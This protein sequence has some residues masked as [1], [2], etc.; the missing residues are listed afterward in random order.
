MNWANPT[1]SPGK[2]VLIALDQPTGSDFL[3]CRRRTMSF[4]AQNFALGIA[5]IDLSAKLD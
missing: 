3:V 5:A 1:A 4:D 2:R